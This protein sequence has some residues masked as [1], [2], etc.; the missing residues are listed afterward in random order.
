[1]EVGIETGSSRLMRELMRGK[2][3][4]YEPEQWR[5]I[6]KQSI[7][8]LNDNDICPLGTLVMGLPGETIDDSLA[9][10]ELIDDLKGM[11]LF[12]VPLLFTSEEECL[13]RESRQA[14]LDN[15]TDLHWDFIATCWRHNI[16]T[17]APKIKPKVMFGSLLLYYLYYRWKHGPQVIYPMMKFSGFPESFSRAPV[18]R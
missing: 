9:T 1:M 8:I 7:G 15:L 6:V 13:L 12:Y 5:E 17:W 11:K 16:E 4:P 2:M 10:M 3:L 14:E 18:R